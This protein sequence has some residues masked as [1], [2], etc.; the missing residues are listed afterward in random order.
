MKIKENNT[1][2]VNSTQKAIEVAERK[3]MKEMEEHISNILPQE[4]LRIIER[5]LYH[6]YCMRNVYLWSEN[7]VSENNDLLVRRSEWKLTAFSHKG[8]EYEFKITCSAKNGRLYTRRQ[9]RRNDKRTNARVLRTLVEKHYKGVLYLALNAGLY[10][11]ETIAQVKEARAEENR[12]TALAVEA[13]SPLMKSKTYKSSM[14]LEKIGDYVFE[15][16]SIQSANSLSECY[17]NYKKYCSDSVWN[18]IEEFVISL[19]TL[20]PK[21]LHPALEA[22]DP[23]AVVATKHEI[24]IKSKRFRSFRTKAPRKIKYKATFREWKQQSYICDVLWK[25]LKMETMK[26][27]MDGQSSDESMINFSKGNGRGEENRIREGSS[28]KETGSFYTPSKLGDYLADQL[29]DYRQTGGDTISIL[30]P[31]VG[32]GQ[33]LE[34]LIS[35]IYNC[36]EFK[37]MRIQ[38]NAFDVDRD[39]LNKTKGELNHKYP[40]VNFDF[41]EGDFVDAFI[42]GKL[43]GFKFDYI[44]ANPPFIRNTTMGNERSKFLSKTFNLN[45]RADMS[46]YFTI[47]ASQLLT[48]SGICG[49]I[50]SNKFMSVASGKNMREHLLNNVSIKRII[51]FGDTK[52]FD[53]SVLPA[54]MIFGNGKTNPQ[55]VRAT[56]IYESDNSEITTNVFLNVFDAIEQSSN[57]LCYVWETLYLIKQGTLNVQPGQGTWTILDAKEKRFLDNVRKNTHDTFQDVANIR[58]GVK[59]GADSV[60]IMNKWDGDAQDKPELLRTLISSKNGGKYVAKT[61]SR[62]LIVY[63]HITLDGKTVAANL[64][65]Y[66]NTKQYLESHKEKLQKRACLDGKSMKWF[67]IQVH[68]EEAAWGKK[69]VVFRDILDEPQFWLDDSGAVV[70]GNCFWLQLKKGIS[71]DILYLILGVAN[72]SFII[73]YYDATV[74]NKI[75]S[76]RRRFEKQS[77]NHFPLPDPNAAESKE[78]IHQV[79]KTVLEGAPVNQERINL[80]VHSLFTSPQV[81]QQQPEK[82]SA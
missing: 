33:L 66:P 27:V 22:N 34:S 69:K 43:E 58:I 70:D 53:A 44:I 7:K 64:E 52:L 37:G 10:S 29:I 60:F 45:G 47:I 55:K 42:T 5:Y 78:I 50:L 61:N 36:Q 31:S 49:M 21:T 17:A 15:S 82:H 71:E 2:M 13:L 56:T 51:D 57:E 39:I 38:V 67:G 74:N 30:E 6:N 16:R 26:L 77:V 23:N 75:F 20:D 76:G 35:K 72:S 48:E 4:K 9:V 63:P 25:G 65:E 68:Q 46:H 1:K 32:E 14:A 11:T 18:V 3:R 24:Q 12:E 41:Y 81:K 28:R 59:T 79:K 19:Y 40:E 73:K 8:I 80:L 54:I 62:K